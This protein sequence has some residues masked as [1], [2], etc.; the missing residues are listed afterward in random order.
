MPRSKESRQF[1]DTK[2]MGLKLLDHRN[3]GCNILFVSY[4]KCITNLVSSPYIFFFYLF[5]SCS[6]GINNITCALE[7]TLSTT[8]KHFA[9]VKYLMMNAHIH[10]ISNIVFDKWEW[11]SLKK[12]YESAKKEF[13]T[14]FSHFFLWCHIF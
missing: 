14:H 3:F 5:Y 8:P 12:W 9:L 2:I 4:T 6:V 1:S 11:Y 10:F 13:F 7:G